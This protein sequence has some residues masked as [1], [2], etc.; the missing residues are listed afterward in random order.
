MRGTPNDDDPRTLDHTTT[1]EQRNRPSAIRLS[2]VRDAAHGTRMSAAP[3]LAKALALAG[4]GMHIHPCRPEP[5][6]FVR[7]RDGKKVTMGAKTGRTSNGHLDATTDVRVIFDWWKRWPDSLVGV[8]AGAS[9][10]VCADIDIDPDRDI[11][12]HET[13]STAGL[14]PLPEA[15]EYRTRRGGTHYVYEAPKGVQLDGQANLG[16]M[17]G[18]DR[19]GGSSY[20]VWWGDTAPS[21]RS[22]LGKKPPAW[23]I[24]PAAI[25]TRG[26]ATGDTTAWLA[27]TVPGKATK[28]VRAARDAV[29]SEGMGHPEML[30][31][32]T[33]LVKLGGERGAGEAY[34]LA[35]SVYLEKY[36]DYAQRW[37][38]AADGSVRELG[39][40][41]MTLALTKTERKALKARNRPEAIEERTQKR[42]DDYRIR[43]HAERP[44]EAGARVLEDG[45][46]AVELADA[47]SDHWAWT[48]GR[49]LMHW[50][51]RVWSEAEP[52]VLVEEVRSRL[53]DIEVDEHEAAVRRGDNKGIDK[54]RTL[55]SRNRARAVSDLVIGRLALGDKRFDANPNLLNVQNGVVDLR[56][57]T[58]LPHDPK[59]Y[60]TKIAAAKYDPKADMALWSKALTALPPKVAAW[61]KVRFGQA[62]TGYTPDDDKLLLFQ[63]NGENGKTTIFAAIREVLGDTLEGGYAVTVP[64]RLL[65]ADPGDHPTT[66]M[67]L[68]GARLAVFEELP[69]GRNLNVKRLKDTVGTTSI[70]ARRMR[71]DD[72]TF[73]ATH[74]LMGDTNYQ[75]IVAETDHGTWRRL[76]LVRFPY[77]FVK[78][79]ADIKHGN[80][81]LGD[82]LVRRHFE[83]HA[84]AGVLRWLVEGARQWYDN[85]ERL[86][87]D[88]KTVRRDTRAWRLDADPVLGYLAE[89]IDADP[90]S[91]IT[92]DDLA[93]D[94]NDHLERRGHRHWSAQTINAR[95]EG[96]VGMAGV[97]RKRVKFGRIRPSRPPFVVR[98]LSP[99]TQAWVGIRFKDEGQGAPMSPEVAD[100]ER[101]MHS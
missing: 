74:A 31:A 51:G 83:S 23:L 33:N 78:T 70:T 36:P 21:S 64:D 3:N 42:K 8:A 60:L 43:I 29:T 79:K 85:G 30:T 18:V 34:E 90:N 47:M 75:A 99:N 95:F 81:R 39:M 27:R 7:K 40:P 55:L 100:L 97:E 1:G 65:T 41:P 66:L 80:D 4:L 88:P 96:H 44:A 38:D 48:K 24:A 16:G 14:L 59:L 12:G 25:K 94:F 93:R 72:V 91:A 13:L 28:A 58:L 49:G 10:V 26:T 82:P 87:Q 54:A 76:A 89:H 5:E 84:D 63:A 52:H 73:K 57:S 67:M 45:P 37:D 35:R 61:L 53:D 32:V 20:F 68:M 92:T 11:N 98:P 77:T 56:T 2:F 9:G 69:E 6:T 22:A 62:A 50:T 101:R 46:L 71:Q 17:V 19:R 86:P 15:F